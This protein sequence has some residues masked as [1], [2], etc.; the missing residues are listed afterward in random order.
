MTCKVFAAK[1]GISEPQLH[2]YLRGEAPASLEL[3][4][5]W[6]MLLGLDLLPDLPR[7]SEELFPP[8]YR[9]WLDGWEPGEG[10][11]PTFR[12]PSDPEGISW[13]NLIEE[14]CR[15]VSGEMAAGTGRWLLT[16]GFLHVALLPAVLSQVEPDRVWVDER[17]PGSEDGRVE[18]LL[19][20]T[21]RIAV[22]VHYVDARATATA[23]EAD[24]AATQL[25]DAVWRAASVE[26]AHQRA[27]VIAGPPSVLGTLV[28]NE[29]ELAPVLSEGAGELEGQVW[30]GRAAAPAAPLPVTA[31]L[32][33]EGLAHAQAVDC[34]VLGLGIHKSGL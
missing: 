1:S 8:E 3:L 10:R 26:Q 17:L 22:T 32:S 21:R 23:E 29:P 4:L 9:R 16:G 14:A 20:G 19:G 15:R 11:L 25:L 34:R 13:E 27:V 31:T 7:A 18:L 30:E 2:R 33:V 28:H 24:R 12:P 6:G 5:A